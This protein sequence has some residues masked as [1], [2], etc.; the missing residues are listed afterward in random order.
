MNVMKHCINGRQKLIRKWLEESL[1]GFVE[2]W[3]VV[4]D[5]SL[6]ANKPQPVVNFINVLRAAFTR[7]NPKSAKNTVKQSFW[8]F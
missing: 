1:V 3:M 8:A 5:H 6:G 2:R 7:E 4:P